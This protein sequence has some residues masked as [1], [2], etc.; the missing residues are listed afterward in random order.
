MA[1][2]LG[3]NPGP[4]PEGSQLKVT[5][6]LDRLPRL[7]TGVSPPTAFAG[8]VHVAGGYEQLRQAFREAT[9]GTIPATPPGQ[10]QC[11]SLTDPSVLGP[12][13][14]DGKHVLSYLG[15]HAPARLYSGQV[16][17]QRD[18][19]VVRVLDAV[20]A[21]LEEP[22]ET[23]LALD[24]DGNPCLEALAPQDVEQA[25]AMPG[26]HMFH[27][28]LSWPWAP[29]G[30][31]LDTPAQ[32]WGVHT[33]WANVLTCGAGAVRG[34]SVSGVAGHNAAM[35]VLEATGR[36]DPGRVHDDERSL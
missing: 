19:T 25:L 27:G 9:R 14:T 26:G 20:N 28:P 21:H 23:L 11:H 7:R 15:L 34:G 8:T 3:E 17:A 24:R 16:A 36:L 5:M 10:L 1:L 18:E 22:I 33:G 30:A 4:R 35:A 6:L 29:D 31:C 32:R 13:A 12:L 2:L